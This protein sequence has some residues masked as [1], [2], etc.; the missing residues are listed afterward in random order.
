MNRFVS[1]IY[2]RVN[3]STLTLLPILVEKFFHRS[4]R[5]YSIYGEDLILKAILSRMRYQ[6]NLNISLNYIDIGAW[7]PL[8]GSNTY[9]SY[10]DGGRGTVVEPNRRMKKLW[11]ALRPSDIFLQAACGK[12]GASVFFVFEEDSAANTISPE[13]ASMIASRE[14]KNVSRTYVVKTLTL[15]EIVLHHL[16]HFSGD[17]FLDIDVEG[18]DF[19]IISSETFNGLLR[20]LIIMIEDTAEEVRFSNINRYLEELSYRLIARSPITS[21]YID[22][23]RQDIF[24]EEKISLI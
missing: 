19:D 3:N 16:A 20:P 4:S 23:K 22:L 13:F 7:R 10:V 18:M 11:T 5:S 2:T 8:R 17:Y 1:N 21:F 12:S 6:F 24:G 14:S 9:R 15:R